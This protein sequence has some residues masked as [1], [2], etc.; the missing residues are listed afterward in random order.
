MGEWASCSSLRQ[1]DK[2]LDWT[3]TALCKVTESWKEK[4]LCLVKVTVT[5]MLWIWMQIKCIHIYT[6][7]FFVLFWTDILF[8]FLRTEKP[9]I[10]T[11]TEDKFTDLHTCL[12]SANEYQYKWDLYPSY[13]V[14]K[15]FLSSQSCHRRVK[16]PTNDL[17]AVQNSRSVPL[18]TFTDCVVRLYSTWMIFPSLNRHQT[19]NHNSKNTD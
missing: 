13:E 11:C 8:I 18:Q 9:H 6:L 12:I 7:R 4:K 19:E 1:D 5:L 16:P 3:L 15:Y 17:C 10:M 2:S 14:W